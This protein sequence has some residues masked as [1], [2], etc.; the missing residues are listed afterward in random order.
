MLCMHITFCLIILKVHVKPFIIPYKF[1]ENEHTGGS[2]I[3]SEKG[4]HL[5]IMF[6]NAVFTFNCFDQK[7]RS[8]DCVGFFWHEFE[9]CGNSKSRQLSGDMLLELSFATTLMQ[10]KCSHLRSC[11]L[12]NWYSRIISSLKFDRPKC[13]ETQA[14]SRMFAFWA[15]V[16][17]F[18][19]STCYMNRWT[20]FS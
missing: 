2:L 15:L 16:D 5:L 20:Q 8:S 3:K 13:Q 17:T 10:W 6:R 9:R 11:W 1:V 7:S 18:L 4:T 12:L 19:S 14:A